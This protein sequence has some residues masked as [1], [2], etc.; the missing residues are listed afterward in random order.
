MTT[1]ERSLDLEKEIESRFAVDTIR[2]NGWQMWSY[3]RMQHRVYLQ[4]AALKK[5]VF[6]SRSGALK[7]LK[8][9]FYGLTSLFGPVDYFVLSEAVLR[10]K[11]NGLYVDKSFDYLISKL[12]P[13]RTLCFEATTF[14][15]QSHYP[16][17]KVK[18]KR[19][20]SYSLVLFLSLPFFLRRLKILNYGILKS[21]IEKYEIPFN[22]RYLFKNVLSQFSVAKWFFRLY[23]PKAIFVTGYYGKIPFIRAAKLRG[24]P[25]VEM[26]HGFLQADHFAY[27]S[28]LKLDNTFFPDYLL[29]FGDKETAYFEKATAL[30]SK[31]N[32]VP[33]G[34]Y[35]LDQLW[36]EFTPN[37]N[38]VQ[39]RQSNTI[40]IAVSGVEEQEKEM[41][42]FLREAV[43]IEPRLII[44]YCPKFRETQGKKKV[45]DF[46]ESIFLVDDLNIYEA[47]CHSDFHA[48]TWSTCALEAPSLGVPNILMDIDGFATHYLGGDLTDQSTTRFADSPHSFVSLATAWKVLPR[49][50]IRDRNKTHFKPNFEDNIDAFLARSKFGPTS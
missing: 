12:G 31:S 22:H 39:R 35:I 28:R 44:L 33:V 24:I 10:R 23:R 30:V 21:V 17:R 38:W 7:Q 45:F 37:P 1:L 29:C 6:R 25:V 50:Q 5:I 9:S 19:I 43:A 8:N 15:R 3:L 4:S 11:V 20:L 14:Q 26:Q 13:K 46:P 16:K 32:V 36:R 47:I 40:M 41:I 2:V 27:N 34:S 18:T 48:T 42:S 49:Q